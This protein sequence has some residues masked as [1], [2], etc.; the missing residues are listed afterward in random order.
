MQGLELPAPPLLA[1]ADLPPAREQ[2]LSPPAPPGPVHRFPEPDDTT[3]Q[4]RRRANAGSGLRVGPR[5]LCT[6]VSSASLP[7]TSSGF[8]TG[9]PGSSSVPTVI[10]TV[11]PVHNFYTTLYVVCIIYV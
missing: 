2:P 9:T 8:M 6:V 7:G 5:V 3:G 11:T 1:E 4:A 10:T